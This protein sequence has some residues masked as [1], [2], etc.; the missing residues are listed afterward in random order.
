[1]A[2]WPATLPCPVIDATDARGEGAIRTPMDAGPSKARRRFSAVSRYVTAEIPLDATQRGTLD[3]FYADTL[4]EGVDAFDIA[5]PF[6]GATVSA[7]FSGPVSYAFR[8]KAAGGARWYMA[9]VSLE[10]L[11]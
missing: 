6:G 1:M 9:A 3:S 8:G 2:S 7:R 11:P 4:G 10:I 5:D